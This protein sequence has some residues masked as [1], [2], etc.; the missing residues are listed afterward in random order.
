MVGDG[1]EAELAV[2]GLRGDV[3]ARLGREDERDAGPHERLVVDEDDGQ[4][5]RRRAAQTWRAARR[6]ASRARCGS[7]AETSQPPA[8]VATGVERAADGAAPAR[9]CPASPSPARPVRGGGADRRRTVADRD[10]HALAVVGERPTVAGAPGACC[11]TL[12]SD[13]WTTR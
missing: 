6:G 9:P 12:A 5:P 10:L 2:A 11:R 1:D 13:S 3:D 7:H 8:R 4:R